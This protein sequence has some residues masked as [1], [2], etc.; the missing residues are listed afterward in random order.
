MKKITALLF[1]I[2]L[3]LGAALSASAATYESY[4]YNSRSEAVKSPAAYEPTNQLSGGSIGVGDFST[5][6]DIY[7]AYDGKIYICDSGNNRIV[8][9]NGDYSLNRV[10]DEF[11]DGHFTGKFENPSGIFADK[12]TGILYIADTDNAR[13]I[14]LDGEL[15]MVKRFDR[16][17][18]SD[19]FAENVVFAPVKVAVDNGGRVFIV[20]RDVYEGLMQYDSNGNFLGFVGANEVSISPI[21]YFWKKISTK[22]QASKLQLTLPTE[23]S[24]LEIDEDGFIYTTTSIINTKNT[25]ILVRRQNPSGDDVLHRSTTLTIAGDA[26]YAETGDEYTTGASN[27]V[28]VTVNGNGMY[29]LLDSKR[30]RIFTY[31]FDGNLLY[32]FGGS[33]NNGNDLGCFYTPTAMVKNG[34]D[35]AVLDI[36]NGMITVFKATEYG[37]LIN[38]AVADNYSG[39][40]TSAAEKWKEILKRNANFEQAYVGIG[41]AE[42]RSGSY[43]AAMNNFKLGND[44][45]YYSKAF[46]LYRQQWLEKNFIWVA[47]AVVAALTALSLLLARAEKNRTTADRKIIKNRVRFAFHCAVSP[48][49]GFYEMKRENKGLPLLSLGILIFTVMGLSFSKELTGFIINTADL[50]SFMEAEI[51]EDYAMADSIAKFGKLMR[52]NMMNRNYITTLKDEL[53]N[54]KYYLELEVLR[55][56]GRIRYAIECPVGYDDVRVPKFIFQ[57]IVENSVKY[58]KT[59]GEIIKIGINVAPRDKDIY[60]TLRDNGRGVDKRTLQSLNAQFESGYYKQS[61]E[62]AASTKVGLKN[63]NQRLRLIYDDSY[64]LTV[65]SEENE[66]FEVCIRIPME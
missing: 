41:I 47:A 28:D 49:D 39:K 48:F 3:L 42:L 4:T 62:G 53:S 66:Y 37:K 23:F 22:A 33:K 31:D 11:K 16:P 43:K 56:P 59:N 7:R 52:Y 55:F 50:R 60:I 36:S 65:S 34:D 20:S 5:P 6:A 63:I 51:K 15:N 26:D 2:V 30:G 45:S 8:I 61:A 54:L 58:A 9:L 32:I 46:K 27:F 12:N 24:N 64:H 19:L 29:S 25:S 57:P 17:E 35:F 13:V 1:C 38:S 14:G 10:I 21:D 44:R 18:K 40:Y